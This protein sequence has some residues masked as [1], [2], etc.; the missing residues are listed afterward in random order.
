M[1]FPQRFCIQ[2]IHLT[3]KTINYGKIWTASMYSPCSVIKLRV[4]FFL[5]WQR[6][7]ETGFSQLKCAVEH[8][9]GMHNTTVLRIDCS[10]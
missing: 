3:S 10:V 5:L 2:L 4:F 9:C 7:E 1:R 8:V 6:L